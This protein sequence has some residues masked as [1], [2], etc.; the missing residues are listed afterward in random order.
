L[1]TLLKNGDLVL[2]KI[3]ELALSIYK[4]LSNS[5]KDLF[6]YSK[7]VLSDG[8]IDAKMMVVARDLGKDEI[9]EEVPLIGQAGS[10]FRLAENELGIETYKTNIVPFK[11]K[12]NQAF[13]KEIRTKF[14]PVLLYQIKL[15]KP[16]IIIAMGNESLSELTGLS[17]GGIMQKIYEGDV[18]NSAKDILPKC[19]I[20]P[21]IHPSFLIRKGITMESLK[22]DSDH[23]QLV[24]E[25]LISPL[26]KANK[27]L[28]GNKVKIETEEIFE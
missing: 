14:R 20:Y 11:P 17:A 12:N 22:T 23:K 2:K 26:F 15:V 18:F 19:L 28:Q 3:E 10:L 6:E 21:C 9:E 25:L 5:E 7:C 4:N 27:Y 13:P 1:S 16:E 8:P 24:T